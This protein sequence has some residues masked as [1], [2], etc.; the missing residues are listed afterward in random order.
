MYS[1]TIS[2]SFACH[3]CKGTGMYLRTCGS[4]KSASRKEYWV[5]KSQIRIKDHICGRSANL[6]NYL[7]PQ[8]CG[9]YLR[10]AQLCIQAYILKCSRVSEKKCALVG[11]EV[12][13]GVHQQ[14]H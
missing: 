14:S 3:I 5:R 6:T 7:S 9:T 1:Y 2:W 11:I 8:I 13:C 10:T 4:V 12:V